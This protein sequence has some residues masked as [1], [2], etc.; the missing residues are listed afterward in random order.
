MHQGSRGL[1]QSDSPLRTPC[2]APR[3]R[4]YPEKLLAIMPSPLVMFTNTVLNP[5]IPL[6][7]TRN[8]RRCFPPWC[9]FV[10]GSGGKKYKRMSVTTQYDTSAPLVSLPDVHLECDHLPELPLANTEGLDDG[11]RDRIID[12]LLHE[13]YRRR[14]SVNIYY[15][16]ITCASP[17]C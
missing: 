15:E 9:L 13:K 3:Y 11:A 5:I 14:I 12:L 4:S 1:A 17:C 8:S 7:G 2:I 16:Y 6:E 10:Q